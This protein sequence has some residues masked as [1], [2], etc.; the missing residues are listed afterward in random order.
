MLSQLIVY[1]SENGTSPRPV[2]MYQDYGQSSPLILLNLTTLQPTCY[3]SS[4]L[5]YGAIYTNENARI[6][7]W[8]CVDLI[9]FGRPGAEASPARL[10]SAPE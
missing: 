4:L 5:H 8:L 6:E 1:F 7:L 2:S 3:S 10:G 9:T